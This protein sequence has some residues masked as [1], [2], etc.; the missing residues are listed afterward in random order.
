MP[1]KKRKRTTVR[2][3]L[4]NQ[5]GDPIVLQFEPS[6][7]SLTDWTPDLIKSAELV[8][9]GGNLRLAADLCEEMLADDR[10]KGVIETRVEG[11]LGL[12]LSFEEGVGRRKRSAKHAL[13]AEEDW[14]ASCPEDQT[15]AVMKW[16]ILL[17]AGLFQNAW[18]WRDN[19]RV[20]GAIAHYRERFLRYDEA[21]RGWKVLVDPGVEIDIT[22]G[23]GQWGLYTPCGRHMPWL[24]GAWRGL[25]RW[26][27]VKQLARSDWARHS[28]VHGSPARVAERTDVK[29]ADTVSATSRRQIAEELQALGR[30]TGIVMPPGYKLTLVEAVARTWE[31]FQAQINMANA[32]ITIILAGQN[33]TTEVSGGSLAAAQVHKEIRGDKIRMDDQTIST[34]I[35]DQNLV[36][37]AGFNFGEPGLAPWPRR[38]V[39][40]PMNIAE[41]GESIGKLGDG[42][43][44][45]NAAIANVRD[46]D[47]D[48]VEVD[49]LELLTKA[50]VPLVK[51]E[52]PSDA[53]KS[54]PGDGSKSQAKRKPAKLSPLRALP[55]E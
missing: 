32:A 52:A 34:T 2:E 36:Y 17:G 41:Q 27:L 24:H 16:G 46:E 43:Q 51:R 49:A 28:E 11:L 21:S 38:Q 23:D 13:E 54:A 15:A 9:Q 47:G 50:G 48:P 7:R 14:D 26:W 40:P 19:G 53:T 35:H 25:S 31:M 1:T 42:I 37:W 5:G 30:D 6:S 20:V 29:M 44:K 45:M 55:N 22:P 8:A 3:A 4:T 10:I 18:T 39:A 12:P 33:L